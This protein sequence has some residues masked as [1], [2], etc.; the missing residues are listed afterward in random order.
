MPCGNSTTMPYD[1]FSIESAD[2]Q[3]PLTDLI[4]C[5]P[6]PFSVCAHFPFDNGLPLNEYSGKRLLHPT[7]DAPFN[8]PPLTEL[9]RAGA[10]RP[11]PTTRFNFWFVGP[12]KPRSW[13]YV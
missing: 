13:I 5:A 7:P 4:L 6:P 10:P 1:D 11:T 3:R 8:Q 2:F 12:S 9:I